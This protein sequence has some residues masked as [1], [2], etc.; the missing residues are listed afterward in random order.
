MPLHRDCTLLKVTGR[1]SLM[2][3]S[4]WGDQD[5][6]SPLLWA[7]WMPEPGVLF[8][9]TFSCFKKNMWLFAWRG[10]G[11]LP[12]VCF[13][14]CVWGRRGGQG[15]WL[16]IHLDHMCIFHF[17]LQPHIPHPPNIS[18]PQASPPVCKA[19]RDPFRVYCC[20]RSSRWGLL[21]TWW[22][23]PRPCH[24]AELSWNHCHL[25]SRL[26]FSFVLKLIPFILT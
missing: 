8:P 5:G 15:Q 1:A 3:D 7:F 17:P 24:I 20:P 9:G 4:A 22:L 16:C 12:G 11:L 14:M 26:L 18:E 6:Q 2:K 21:L 25:G 23:S 10:Y 19:G 13:H